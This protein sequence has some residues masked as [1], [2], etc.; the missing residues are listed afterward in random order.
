MGGAVNISDERISSN[1]WLSEFL[2]SDTADR[3]GI[4]NTPTAEVIE[5]VRYNAHNMELVREACDSRVVHV[6]S[7]VRVE[8]L[9]RIICAR[10][11]VSW[12]NFR[13]LNS[14]SQDAWAEY[15]S[16]KEHPLG[17]ATDFTIPAFGSPMQVCRRILDSGI[18]FQKLIYEISW[19]HISWP[20]HGQ[21]ALGYVGTIDW[22]GER[23]GLLEPRPRSPQ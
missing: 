2:R 19:V 23:P 20:R 1:F 16:R 11:F 8:A 10:A 15:L 7:G 12:C 3:M 21:E 22:K 5:N 4:D 14:N 17:L 13:G 6:S 9:E 18:P